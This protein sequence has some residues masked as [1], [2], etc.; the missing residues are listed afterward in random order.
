MYNTS[1]NHC[2][3][4]WDCWIKSPPALRPLQNL[5]KWDKMALFGGFSTFL[6][7]PPN[8]IFCKKMVK[9]RKVSHQSGHWKRLIHAGS[10]E[11][12]PMLSANEEFLSEWRGSVNAF[13]NINFKCSLNIGKVGETNYGN[14]HL[15]NAINICFLLVGKMRV[16]VLVARRH[17]CSKTLFGRLLLRPRLKYHYFYRQPTSWSS[18]L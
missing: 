9:I 7:P 18:W 8:N 16:H 5:E 15:D 13:S 6:S 12:S 10:V 17:F 1:G 14:P 4:I 2:G 11:N 3:N